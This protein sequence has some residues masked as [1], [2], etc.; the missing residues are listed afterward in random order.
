MFDVNFRS[1][2]PVRFFDYSE[3]EAFLFLEQ[4]REL[5][6]SG[7]P[8]GIRTPVTAVKGR[9]PRPLDDGDRFAKSDMGFLFLFTKVF[10]SAG[11]FS[12]CIFLF[13]LL[14]FLFASFASFLLLF[15]LFC[16]SLQVGS[17]TC[18]T[19]A[20]EEG[21]KLNLSGIEPRDLLYAM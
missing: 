12:Y 19:K 3:K 1:A 15:F 10:F 5:M 7:V 2:S 14:L 8:K 4:K 18:S 21:I 9:C 17:R 11:F 16:P 6:L 20:P 13:C